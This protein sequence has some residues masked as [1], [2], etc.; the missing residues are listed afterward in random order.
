M[1]GAIML[2]LDQ[3]GVK[4][5]EESFNEQQ[6]IHVD[7][8]SQAIEDHYLHQTNTLRAAANV[9]SSDVDTQEAWQEIIPFFAPEQQHAEFAFLGQIDENGT[10]Q[11]WHDILPELEAQSLQ[12]IE[13]YQTQMPDT[14]TIFVTPM[15]ATPEVQLYAIFLMFVDEANTNNLLVAVINLNEILLS[16]VAPLRSGEFG[17]A[18]VQDH[19]GVVIYDHETEIIGQNVADLHANHADILYYDNLFLTQA[20]GTGEYVFTVQRG[21]EERRKLLAWNTVELGNEHL[22]VAMSAPDTEISALISETRTQSLLGAVGLIFLLGLGGIWYGALQQRQLRYR[23]EERTLELLHERKQLKK[24]GHTLRL[25]LDAANAG[26]WTWNPKTSEVT[27]DETTERMYGMEPGTFDSSY[28]TWIKRV[29]PD[30]IPHITNRIQESLNED[31]P[32]SAE[33]RI[34][35]ADDGSQRHFL[36]QGTLLRDENGEPVQFI[37]VTLDITEQK[38]N[39]QAL[40]KTAQRLQEAQHIARLSHWEWS[41]ASD[42]VYWSDEM[43][44]MLGLTPLHKV[45]DFDVWLSH[46]HPDDRALMEQWIDEVKQGQQK[47]SSTHRMIKS[48]GDLL[49]VSI[50]GSAEKDENGEFIGAIGTIQDV[51]ERDQVTRQLQKYSN[52]LEAL[53]EIAIMLTSTLNLTEILNLLLEELEKLVPFYSASIIFDD[54]ENIEY[55]ALR[56]ISNEMN[57]TDIARDVQKTWHYQQLKLTRKPI[58]IDNVQ[59]NPSWIQREET[60]MVRSWMGIPLLFKGKFLGAMNLDYNEIDFFTEEHRTTAVAVAHQAAFA[61]EN[62][63]LYGDL[64]H[65][66]ELRTRELQESE[67]RARALVEAIPDIVIRINRNGTIMDCRV[68]SDYSD[69]FATGELIG[70]SIADTFF[71]SE[72]QLDKQAITR[73]LEEGI[74]QTYELPHKQSDG[75][76]GYFEIRMIKQ[77]QDEV[78]VLI[79]DITIE[80]ELRAQQQ[81][82]IG[83]VVHELRTPLQ[84][85][86]NKTY[87]M[88]KK[89]D[90]LDSHLKELEKVSLMMSQLIDDLLDITRFESGIIKLDKKVTDVTESIQNIVSQLQ[91]IAEEKSINISYVIEPSLPQ[92]IADPL[93]IHQVIMNLVMNAINYTESG[94]I[95]IHASTQNTQLKIAVEDSGVGIPEKF[96]PDKIFEPFN[97]ANKDER[98][99]GTG[100]G[101]AITRG[102]IELHGGT[103]SVDSV[104]GKGSTFTILL[105]LNGKYTS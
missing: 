72:T 55:V 94:Y 4:Q 28:D 37:G 102:I 27:W 45:I 104:V 59:N 71:A 22:T 60:K 67:A 63:R 34:T 101:L 90:T 16:S 52:Q 91:T 100:L 83:T 32:Y 39:E 86:L 13:M 19:Y 2:L 26:V 25:S 58:I 50:L 38:R 46:T 43:Y 17:A 68:P 42:D 75:T 73:T 35:R 1:Y 29:H 15:Y 105:P 76:L 31:T 64:E 7:L 36:G 41:K 8:A 30:D 79:R 23:V 82:F 61:I 53:R 40:V 85:I 24:Q 84:I 5:L 78:T 93:R 96:L 70:M 77:S 9:I 98:F 56:H 69:L 10:L 95:K 14:D 103:I 92:V 99:K 18:W 57:F 65:R 11:R 66:V 44:H 88:R 80:R 21:G 87:L 12:I 62:A 48:D 33:F 74:M 3:N 49:H 89:P 20:S 51:T 47:T 81:R 6:F 54:E 97:R